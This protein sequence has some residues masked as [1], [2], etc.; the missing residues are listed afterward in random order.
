MRLSVQPNPTAN[1]HCV[2]QLP[3][4]MQ[5][6]CQSQSALNH[7]CAENG[8]VC[9]DLLQHGNITY[10]KAIQT[11]HRVQISCVQRAHVQGDFA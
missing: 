4:F 1:S 5:A 11:K 8:K 6:V 9:F 7:P 2:L 10:G 3:T